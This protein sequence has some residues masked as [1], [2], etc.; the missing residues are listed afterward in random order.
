MLSFHF[1]S[2]QTCSFVL[3]FI[4]V[5]KE[6]EC[7]LS[8]L[9]HADCS[10]GHG[11]L[12][13][14]ALNDFLCGQVEVG[15]DWNHEETVQTPTV[16]QSDGVALTSL[17]ERRSFWLCLKQLQ[18]TH[19]HS[20]HETAVW[21]LIQLSMHMWKKGRLRAPGGRHL[22]ISLPWCWDKVMTSVITTYIP[23]SPAPPQPTCRLTSLSSLFDCFLSFPHAF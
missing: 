2:C 6:P 7:L 19:P 22:I 18:H 16:L 9:V 12:A 13:S 10:Q 21:A 14:L 11:W 1:L 8:G 4:P 3:G 23:V 17:T 20:V 5:I 15:Q